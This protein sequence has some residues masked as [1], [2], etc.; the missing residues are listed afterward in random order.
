M[1]Q[2]GSLSNKLVVRWFLWAYFLL[3]LLMNLYQLADRDI[4]HLAA[5]ISIFAP[6]PGFYSYGVINK[7]TVPAIKVLRKSIVIIEEAKWLYFLS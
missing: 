4:I 3:F 2:L 7:R 1:A 5:A 6:A